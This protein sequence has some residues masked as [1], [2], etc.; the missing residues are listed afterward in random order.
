MVLR[1]SKS[2]I[3]AESP[4]LKEPS[5]SELHL[6]LS[7]VSSTV[8]CCMCLVSSV[9]FIGCAASTHRLAR[10]SWSPPCLHLSEPMLTL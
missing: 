5:E 2:V 8:I 4:R 3:K 7:S 6:D 1:E 9:K 10:Q